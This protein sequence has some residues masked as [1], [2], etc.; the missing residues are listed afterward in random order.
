MYSN[1]KNEYS[2]KFYKVVVTEAG[3]L[4]ICILDTKDL[5]SRLNISRTMLCER[6]SSPTLAQKSMI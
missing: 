2:E 1:E 6:E 4:T 5:Q 3:E